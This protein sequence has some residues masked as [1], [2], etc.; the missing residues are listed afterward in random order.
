[1]ILRAK[2]KTSGCQPEDPLR[3]PQF[4]GLSGETGGTSRVCSVFVPCLFRSPDTRL[5]G[6]LRL[7]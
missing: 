5:K 4:P 3:F 1:M 2:Q 6:L 7:C